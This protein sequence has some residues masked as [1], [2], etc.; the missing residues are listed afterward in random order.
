[1][2]VVAAEKYV[3]INDSVKQQK[4]DLK[5]VKESLMEQLSVSRK[6]VIKLSDGRS[7]ALV[8]KKSKKSVGAKAILDIITAHLGAATAKTIKDAIEASR[9]EP[10]E[11]HSLKISNK[12]EE[13]EDVAMDT[14]EDN[15]E[16]E[17]VDVEE[18]EEDDDDEDS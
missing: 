12:I 5:A 17:N 16:D 13:D 4:V 10:K 8:T 2:S 11:S 9:G 14:T 7:I 1:M 15:V 18:E 6:P 3:S